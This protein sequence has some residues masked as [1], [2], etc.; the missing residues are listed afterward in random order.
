M[1]QICNNISCVDVGKLKYLYRY[2]IAESQRN[3]YPRLNDSERILQAEQD[4]YYD[5]RAFLEIEGASLALWCDGDIYISGLRVEEYQ[6][7]FLLTNLET[8][9]DYRNKGYATK[10]ILSLMKHIE[11]PDCKYLYSHIEKRNFASLSVHQKCGFEILYDYASFV[12]GSISNN[13]YTLRTALKQ[14]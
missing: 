1:F 13:S 3:N 14:K 11:G 4:F 7:G 9:P 6:N 8:D 10:L 5:I 12:D 2:R